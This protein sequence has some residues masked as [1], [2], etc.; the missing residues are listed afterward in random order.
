MGARKSTEIKR[1]TRL[2]RIALEQVAVTSVT[3]IVWKFGIREQTF[4]RQ[5]A[6]NPEGQHHSGSNDFGIANA[7][8]H[9]VTLKPKPHRNQ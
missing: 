3:E 6:C 7:S 8:F 9:L 1:R 5:A 2:D 4:F